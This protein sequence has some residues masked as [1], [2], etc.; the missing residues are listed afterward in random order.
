MPS[1]TFHT[2]SMS[3]QVV[4]CGEV[5]KAKRTTPRYAIVSAAF[6][7][8]HSALRLLDGVT[9]NR[10]AAIEAHEVRAFQLNEPVAFLG[11]SLAEVRQAEVDRRWQQALGVVALE[12]VQS[13]QQRRVRG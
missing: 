10:F 3:V 7:D 13:I 1:A 11:W 9:A 12:V 2:D 6:D 4:S 8:A 5:L